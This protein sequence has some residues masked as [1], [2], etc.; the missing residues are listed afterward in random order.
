MQQLD[1]DHLV[2]MGLEAKQRGDPQQ[3]LACFDA[4]LRQ[5][6]VSAELLYQAGD[7]SHD[8]GMLDQAIE[9]LQHARQL[10]PDHVGA[11]Y[12]LAVALQDK[13]LLEEAVSCYRV[14]ESLRPDHAK[15]YNN[16]GSALMHLG[17]LDEAI[18]C[19]EKAL[20]I[21]TGLFL[22]H[23]NLG[24]A[25][26]RSGD[27]EAAK[28]DF[29]QALRLRPDFAEAHNNYA[30]LL[31]EEGRL[32]QAAAEYRLAIQHNPNLAEAYF[33]L[34]NILVATWHTDEALA[35]LE[36]LLSIDP[37]NVIGH[38]NYLLYA[39]YSDRYSAQ[40]HYRMAREMAQKH[41]AGFE[42][43]AATIRFENV[44]DAN[45]KIR[46]GYVSGDF[47]LHPVGLFFG[48]VIAAHDK[49]QVETWCYYNYTQKDR[50]TEHIASHA[51]HWRDIHG[52][53]DDE[54]EALIRQD[55]IDIL[56][57][58]AG[59]TEANRLMVFARKPAPVQVAWLG[60]F[61]TTG[62]PVMDYLL[63]DEVGVPEANRRYF[64]ETI[65]YLPET[66]LCFSP[67]DY[68]L[69]VAP[70]PAMKN[71]YITFGCFQNMA[72]AGDHVLQAWSEI[73][74][75]LPGSRLR[76]QCR[77]LGDP[78]VVDELIP[79]LQRNGIDTSSVELLGAADHESY[80]AAHAEVDMILDTFPYPGGT[81]TCEALW[82]GVPTL[83]LAGDTLIA[84]Q[85]ASMLTTVG[86]HDWIATNREEYIAK[87]Q[88]FARNLPALASLRAGLREQARVSPLFD[89]PRFT[90]NLEQAYRGMWR[91][92]CERRGT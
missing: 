68:N 62:L 83:T 36:R 40:D 54:V 15:T 21:D 28:S 52:Q 48:G 3:A 70:L 35:L 20:R 71:G 31:K 80:L 79:R 76:W 65:Q 90:R 29:Q 42:Q 55:N 4:A 67:P 38:S 86:L 8:L 73:L 25:H 10:D 64:A 82:M 33:N 27:Y 24:T 23:Y 57:D 81:T 63:A 77:Q 92:W 30:N 22:A 9:C 53:S 69:P 61:D 11:V 60:Y 6:A 74:A 47:C 14:A 51:D 88:S 17:R 5:G 43:R 39:H 13:G 2:R 50:M 19:F 12:T 16:M 7:T 37:N 44:A 26:Y 75:A 32:K 34:A 87:A 84:R 49:S 45:R 58:L 66:R 46:I 78:D 56:V 91:K 1:A 89:A 85:G 59:H 18:V 41:A 72:K